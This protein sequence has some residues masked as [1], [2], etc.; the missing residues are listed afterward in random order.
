MHLNCHSSDCNR[1]NWCENNRA[2]LDGQSAAAIIPLQC[3]CDGRCTNRFTLRVKRQ[4]EA[5]FVSVTQRWRSR[6]AWKTTH[7]HTRANTH[8]HT[9]TQTHPRSLICWLLDTGGIP[10]SSCEGMKRSNAGRNEKWRWWT[11]DVNMMS[12]LNVC[13]SSN[14]QKHKVW[15]WRYCEISVVRFS[16]RLLCC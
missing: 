6:P 9:Q 12:G 11:M 1:I 14:D 10:T 3:V 7:I 13:V 4:T 2:C 5:V 15:I 8:A 16:N